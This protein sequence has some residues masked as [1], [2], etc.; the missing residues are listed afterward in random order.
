[1]HTTQLTKK[2]IWTAYLPTS[3]VYDSWHQGLLYKLYHKYQIKGN[4][5]KCIIN[6]LTR[7]YTRVL[8][9]KGASPWKLQAKGLPQGSSLSPILYI[10][11]TNDYKVKYTDFIKMGCFADDTAFWTKP[12]ILKSLKYKY[13]QKEINRFIDWTKFWKLSI[14]PTKC[15]L[16]K[17]H[18]FIKQP[19][20][21]KYHIE[22]TTLNP[23]K[24]C[25]YLGLHIDQSLNL[26]YHIDNIVSKLNQ[27][28]YQLYFILK[29]GLKL[30][31]KTIIQ[32]YKT[33]SRPIIEY[34]L[35]LF[36]L[37][38]QLQT[39]TSQNKLRCIS[40]Q[41]INSYTCFTNDCEH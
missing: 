23:V 30:L 6:F 40:M 14:N 21:F 8:T 19:F 20:Q 22:D 16:I 18:K 33:K 41:N 38:K 15:S 25:R 17:I 3:A 24:S 37:D 39:T 28:L 26:R 7:R 2:Q 29:S 35:Y 12:S 11:Y 34:A 4:F 1:M 27:N 36:H 5:F 31:P 32:I 9:K 13:L 10:L